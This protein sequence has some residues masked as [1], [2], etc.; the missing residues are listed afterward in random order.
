M[1]GLLRTGL[2]N[3]ASSLPDGRQGRLCGEISILDKSDLWGLH[4]IQTSTLIS[5]T[6][7]TTPETDVIL[8]NPVVAN[9][10]RERKTDMA[11]GARGHDWIT[12]LSVLARHVRKTWN[13]G[14]R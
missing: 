5:A 3:H 9:G 14:R 6:I 1:N 4:S 8:K 2:S 13:R 12:R 11:A 7:S 10:I